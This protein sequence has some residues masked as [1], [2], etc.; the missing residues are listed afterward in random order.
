MSLLH[1]VPELKSLLPMS[2]RDRAR[3][4]QLDQVRAELATVADRVQGI[5]SWHD[6]HAHSVRKAARAGG[7]AMTKTRTADAVEIRLMLGQAADTAVISKR[8]AAALD[9][10]VE[11]LERIAAGLRGG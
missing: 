6:A 10:A 4:A 11:A 5:A 1:R 9:D 8:T 2:R 3:L 7:R